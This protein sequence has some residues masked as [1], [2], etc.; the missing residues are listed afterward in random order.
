MREGS[1]VLLA[2]G[3]L[4]AGAVFSKAAVWG[5]SVG[6]T[7]ADVRVGFE[8]EISGLHPTNPNAKMTQQNPK[9]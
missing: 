9:K 8:G 4:T 1:L 6:E 7:A 5:L 2:V 3:A